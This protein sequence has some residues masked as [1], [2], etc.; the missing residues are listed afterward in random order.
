VDLALREGMGSLKYAVERA[1]DIV[2]LV[3]KT[4]M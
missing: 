4:M 2:G 3:E 1:G